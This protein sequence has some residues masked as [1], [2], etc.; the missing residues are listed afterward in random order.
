MR[1]FSREAIENIQGLNPHNMIFD[2][3]QHRVE[4]TN[5]HGLIVFPAE[6]DGEY[7]ISF[8]RDKIGEIDYKNRYFGREEFVENLR[9][10]LNVQT[11]GLNEEQVVDILYD[12]RNV[13]A[14]MTPETL[15]SVMRDNS[16]I[17]FQ[18]SDP[19]NY[20]Y[21]PDGNVHRI[22]IEYEN[23]YGINIVSK[24]N[25]ETGIPQWEVQRTS[26]R[27][28]MFE[29]NGAKTICT[30]EQ[31]ILKCVEEVRSA[32]INPMSKKYIDSFE[33]NL[34]TSE[35]VQFNFKY[36]ISKFDLSQSG[37][38]E[39][40][41]DSKEYPGCSITLTQNE[42]K[43]WDITME[44]HGLPI[45]ISDVSQA[46][47]SSILNSNIAAYSQAADK[48]HAMNE[49]MA[50]VGTSLPEHYQLAMLRKEMDN[51]NDSQ[52]I[53]RDNLSHIANSAYDGWWAMQEEEN[54]REF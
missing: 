34:S 33:H 48:I 54:T 38:P 5:G 23:G 46:D 52:T 35:A 26:E 51:I 9:N 17:T 8:L 19:Q 47:I 53:E 49:L 14:D 39:W 16:R 43:N 37:K 50:D 7:N 42:N 41:F 20:G 44:K 31:E 13:R 45:T 25:K 11:S 40:H 18:E 3:D 22:N 4:L 1:R 10:I 2:I 36:P 29:W 32:E 21:F 12:L 30:S 6:N 28:G 27:L 24:M 15:A